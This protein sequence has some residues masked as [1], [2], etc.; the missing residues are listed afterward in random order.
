MAKT[1]EIDRTRRLHE[2]PAK[3]HNRWHFDLAPVLEVSP[4]EAL[5]IQTRDASDG[6]IR[7]G[8]SAADMATMDRKA[9]HPLTGPVCVKGAQ[10][11][12]LLEVEYLEIVPERHGWTRF[13]PGFGFLPELFDRPFVVHWDIGADWASSTALPGVRIPNGAFMGTAGVAPSREQLERWSAREAE[14]HARGGVVYL[15]DADCAVPAGGAVAREGLRTIPPRENCGNA[16]VKQLTAGSKLFV[17]V[18]VE[19]ALYS[20]GDGHYAQ[21]DAECCGTAIEMGATAVVRFRL[22][23]GEA[24]R[25][26]I[27]WPR[28][29]HAGYFA[30]PEWAAPRDF[31]ATMG[32]PVRA[33]GRNESGDLTLAAKNAVIQMIELLEERGW[34]REQAYVLCSVAVDLRVSNVVDLPNAVVSALLPEAI[35]RA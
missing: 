12:D 28:F 5:A 17:P 18:A 27:V 11:G 29:A 19:G 30:A 8:M 24:A 34:S 10:P 6:Q 15:P 13:I 4:G 23:K 21:G 26:R 9:A 16:D 31:I 1:I 14:L 35:F 7:P 25:R 3:G 33:D 2:E 22:H 20:V 32:M